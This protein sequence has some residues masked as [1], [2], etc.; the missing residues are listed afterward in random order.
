[1]LSKVD[2]VHTFKKVACSKSISFKR[3]RMEIITF[4]KDVVARRA[5]DIIVIAGFPSP[6]KSRDSSGGRDSL[7]LWPLIR[8]RLSIKFTF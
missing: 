8:R 1:M 5:F 3:L 2:F 7:S 6:A 4:L